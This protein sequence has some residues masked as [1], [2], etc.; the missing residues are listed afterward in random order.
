MVKLCIIEVVVARADAVIV[1]VVVGRG[2]LSVNEVD[3]PRH[4]AVSTQNCGPNSS[5]G[6]SAT[7]PDVVSNDAATG[8]FTPERL[9]IV[10]KVPFAFKDVIAVIS[11]P[12]EA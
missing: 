2:I 5:Q 7:P 11:T 8:A 9:E 6:L 10:R 1:S 3:G 4:I 12:A